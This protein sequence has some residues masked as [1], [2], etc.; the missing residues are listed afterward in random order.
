MSGT[1]GNTG[2]ENDGSEHSA[3]DGGE[4]VV[5]AVVTQTESMR[6]V[7]MAVVGDVPL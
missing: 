7:V 2:S 4:I 6:M 5:K 3:D 1:T